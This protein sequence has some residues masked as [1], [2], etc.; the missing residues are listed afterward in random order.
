MFPY[1]KP[2]GN[3]ASYI[4]YIFTYICKNLKNQLYLPMHFEDIY[5][6]VA[7]IATVI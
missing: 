4:A 7:V 5:L 1:Q 2:G 3:I 6:K